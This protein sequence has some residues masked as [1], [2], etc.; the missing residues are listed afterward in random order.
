DLHVGAAVLALVRV[1]QV[2]RLERQAQ[3]LV[4]VVA[5]RQV[6]LP[7]RFDIAGI[8]AVVF[9]HGRQELPP[10]V[11]G[12][13]DG[14]VLV[15]VDT[16]HVG[17]VRQTDQRE[18]RPHARVVVRKVGFH[19]RVVRLEAEAVVEH[20]LPV[21]L[22]APQRR[23]VLVDDR[24]H[25]VRQARIAGDAADDAR[26]VAR[27][28]HARARDARL[29]VEVGEDVVAQ[30]VRV[31]LR[32]ARGDGGVVVLAA[33]RRGGRRRRLGQGHL[34]GIPLQVLVVQAQRHHAL[35]RV[36]PLGRQVQ[37]LRLHRRQ[38]RIA[39][40]DVGAG[41][42]RDRAVRGAALDLVPA[43]PADRHAV[44]RPHLQLRTQVDVPVERRQPVV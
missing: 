26:Q 24:R 33:E 23:L 27:S 21:D 22:R 2:D 7:V 29:T 41:R 18:L 14:Q 44:A 1:G 43:R 39:A 42:V 16:D 38:A 40:G 3:V 4:D 35:L 9:R 15:F 5:D 31:R 17:R 10:P 11:V 30:A 13:A 6:D 12:E 37:V 28:R 34:A 32:A 19:V 36:V 20:V 25:V 8:G